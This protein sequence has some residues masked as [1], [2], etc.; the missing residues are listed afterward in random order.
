[1]T[2]LPLLHLQTTVLLKHACCNSPQWHP[3]IANCDSH[4]LN[5]RQNAF[6]LSSGTTT[7]FVTTPSIISSHPCKSL[8]LPKIPSMIL[9]L[10]ELPFHVN[11]LLDFPA[12]RI[13]LGYK[14]AQFFDHVPYLASSARPLSICAS[15]CSCISGFR[16][17]SEVVRAC[18]GNVIWFNW[19]SSV[20]LD[21]LLWLGS[22]VELRGLV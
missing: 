12:Q 17:Q 19:G 2:L 5:V 21:R 15:L 13:V 16:R 3:S 7:S 11:L 22:L 6:T 1:M 14:L 20:W 4:F 10:L 9:L 18:L 8:L